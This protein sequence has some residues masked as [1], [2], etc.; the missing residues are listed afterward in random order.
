M[1][2][3]HSKEVAELAGVSVRTLRHYHQVGILPEPARGSNGYR[4]YA[5]V[6]VAVLLRIRRLVDLGVALDRM[7]ALLA[8]VDPSDPSDPSA[9]EV[10]G[11]LDRELQAEVER[12]Q[13]QRSRIAGLL[14]DGRR[15]DLPP[16]PSLADLVATISPDI[17]GLERDAGVVLASLGSESYVEDLRRLGEAVTRADQ[18]GGLSAVVVRFRDLDPAAPDSE[19]EALADDFADLLRGPMRDLRTSGTGRRLAHVRPGQLP[20]LDDDPRLNPAQ[21]KSLTILSD[22]LESDQDTGDV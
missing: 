8:D 15:P 1:S 4:H 17:A 3:M 5:L 21:L 22:R 2:R 7:P 11:E 10:L 12:L 6:H 19:V 14:A 16:G 13:E 9:A 18:E 20:T